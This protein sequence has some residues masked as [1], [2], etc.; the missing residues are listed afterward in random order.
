MRGLL[1]SAALML[2]CL[3]AGSAQAQYPPFRPVQY[4]QPPQYPAFAPPQYPFPAPGQF[5][6][7]DH[8]GHG[9]RVAPPCDPNVAFV[10]SLYHQILFREPDPCGMRTW[11]DRLHHVDIH[12]VQRE[13][14]RSAQAELCDRGLQHRH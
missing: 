13:F 7:H 4:P 9:P 6:G 8:H 1:F 10:T 2:G 5:G 11:L 14:I 3:S 12:C